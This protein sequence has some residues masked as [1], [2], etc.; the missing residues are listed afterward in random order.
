MRNLAVL[1]IFIAT[2]G[3]T[4]FTGNLEVINWRHSIDSQE[5]CL[6]ITGS[7]LNKPLSA[8]DPI[9]EKHNNP[10]LFVLITGGLRQ[11]NPHISITKLKEI[12]RNR[13]KDNE[14]FITSIEHMNNNMIV[15]LKNTEGEIFYS[16]TFN[17]DRR[18]FGCHSGKLIIR[19]IIELPK[20][21]GAHGSAHYSETILSKHDS[22]N[23]YV[24]QWHGSS[25]TKNWSWAI[26]GPTRESGMRSS[27]F[28]E[29]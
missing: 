15:S 13:R 6:S 1:T 27:V 20:G 18:F 14:E 10:G 24:T 22:G 19:E 9:K 4:T 5:N 8:Q 26:V 16:G 11:P 12:D 3:C 28:R 29:I 23:L 7:Y 2:I 17:L 25:P 21:E